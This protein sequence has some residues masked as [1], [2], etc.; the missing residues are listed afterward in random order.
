MINYHHEILDNGLQLI[1]HE[2]DYTPLVV[3][4]LLYQVGSKDENPNRTGFAHLFEHLMFGGSLNLPDYDDIV[5]NAGGDSNAF[6]SNDITNFYASAPANN[7]DVLLWA[8]A[9]RMQNLLLNPKSLANQKKVVIEEF[10]ETCLNQPYGDV[11]HHLSSLV[12]KEHPYRW[13][14]IGKDFSHIK[15][16]TLDEVSQFHEKFYT[17]NNAI[18]V[19][20]GKVNKELAI[21]RAKHWFSGIKSG[22]ILEKQYPSEPEQTEKRLL[23]VASNVPSKALFMVFKTMG[24]L[25]KSYYTL[26]LL[27]DYIAGSKASLLYQNLLKR[28][29]LFIEIDCYLNDTSDA[30][31]LL[32]VEG[33]LSDGI[34]F[35]Q[36]EQ[37]IWNELDAL[38]TTPLESEFLQRQKNRIESQL[39]FSESGVLNKA[40]NLAYFQSI[41]NIEL[42]N[43]EGQK[44]QDITV[45]DVLATAVSVLKPSNCS[46]MYYG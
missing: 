6:T 28:D 19:I 15:D 34:E 40:M 43:S 26:D 18:L 5:Q 20:A 1:I 17:P 4:N 27:S 29:K 24:R 13:P 35:Q 14:V 37:A 31:G 42:I 2:D 39:A 11:W 44:Y 46:V 3:V 30:P 10:K 9:D 7:L 32:I 45:E 22:P 23:A 12:Y 25:D 41:G 8:E 38:I 16:A 33:K 36:A 21:A